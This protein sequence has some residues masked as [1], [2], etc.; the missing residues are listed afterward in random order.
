MTLGKPAVAALA[1]LAAARASAVP[2][3]GCTFWESRLAAESQRCA[4]FNIAWN[5]CTI[6]HCSPFGCIS[7]PG[8]RFSGWM[9]EHFVEVT[10]R[11]GKSVFTAA[12]APACSLQMQQADATWQAR[13]DLVGLRTTRETPST[14]AEFSMWFGRT[15]PVPYGPVGW[16]LA[17]LRDT[18]G[19]PAP[20][21]FSAITE[22]AAE[23]WADR[24]DSGDRRLAALWAPL[25][26]PAC[27]LG[28][29][30]ASLTTSLP[31]ASATVP[32]AV[33]CAMPLA[34]GVQE[35]LALSGASATNPL[36]Q[37]MGALG[38]LLPRTG[39]TDGDPWT[40]AQRVAWRTASLAED[41]FRADVGVRERDRW[42]V[43]WPRVPVPR[44]FAPGSLLRPSTFEPTSALVRGPGYDSA[45]PLGRPAEF[46]FAI[47][48][49][50]TRCLETWEAAAVEAELLTY[51]AV[52]G[53]AC[54][55]MNAA[56]GGGL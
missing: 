20:T 49:E 37:C 2:L 28:A 35:A 26:A 4:S 14:G 21:C 3:H 48:R 22:F 6:V 29:P 24:L 56:S 11:A 50:R 27:T 17:S 23:T 54:A 32:A 9:P 53:A 36:K 12:D 7:Y 16:A 51:P 10:N 15:L 44:C 55:A 52:H 34:T 45:P 8:E 31:G 1:M 43:I 41:Y 38:G 13:G 47:W 39:W 46:V 40:A 5:A 30:V 42:Q 25:T 33:P 18:A 19:S